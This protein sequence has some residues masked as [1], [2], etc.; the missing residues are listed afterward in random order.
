MKADPVLLRDIL[1][2]LPYLG[3]AYHPPCES[4]IEDEFEKRMVNCVAANAEWLP[5]F[6]VTT[7]CSNYRIDFVCRTG[8]RTIGFECDGKE[9]HAKEPDREHDRW[10]DALIMGT[11]KVN[12]I[13]RVP[14]FQIAHHFWR[15][16]HLISYSEPGLLC[17][18]GR[19]NVTAMT[20]NDVVSIERFESA[21]FITY[22]WYPDR[23]AHLS[24]DQDTFEQAWVPMTLRLDY[25]TD[26]RFDG[27]EP[28][29]LHMAR[30]AR[31]HRGKTLKQIIQLRPFRH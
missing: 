20:R 24:D 8:G 19:D 30:F 4:R 31:Q 27:Q 12:A 6:E 11:G 16:L 23:L 26:R 28:E 3:P 2:S 14:G 9:H 7:Q 13:Y 1:P 5:Q 22:R 21:S 18:R 10:R 15:V 29:W 17:E 25:Y